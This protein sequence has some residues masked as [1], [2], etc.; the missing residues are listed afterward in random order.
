MRG[1]RIAL[2]VWLLAGCLPM[3]PAEPPPQVRHTPG[4]FAVIAEGTYDAG[5]WQVRYPNGWRVVQG[6]AAAPAWVV[7]VAPDEQITITLSAAPL[8]AAALAAQHER[9]SRLYRLAPD[10]VVFVR[11]EAPRSALARLDAAWQ[12]VTTTLRPAP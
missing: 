4:P 3:I 1:L 12:L 10:Q 9:R 7:F 6:R 11:G 8:P 5:A 2:I